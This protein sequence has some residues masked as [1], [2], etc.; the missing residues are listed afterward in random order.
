MFRVL[1]FSDSFLKLIQV[2]WMPSFLSILWGWSSG[3]SLVKHLWHGIPFPCSE[4]QRQL[5][6]VDSGA[7]VAIFLKHTL[8]LESVVSPWLSI[9]YMRYFLR[10]LRSSN[11]FLTNTRGY[12][13]WR[14]FFFFGLN[15]MVFSWL[16]IYSVLSCR[17]FLI[18]TFLTQLWSL[19]S[20]VLLVQELRGEAHFAQSQDQD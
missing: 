16:N 18:V 8:R 19:A 9:Y 20:G 17:N 15:L 7:V 2:I 3:V 6:K 1:R 12:G 10:V 13:G 5:S 11:I 4:I 14:F